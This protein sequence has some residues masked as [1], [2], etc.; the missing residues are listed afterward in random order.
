MEIS[1]K[2]VAERKVIKKVISSNQ[3]PPEIADNAPLNAAIAASLPANYNFE[4]H[5]IVWRLK[6]LNVRRVALQFP[7]GKSMAYTMTMSIVLNRQ[8]IT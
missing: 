8:K 5:K 3:V 2:P 1:A 6:Q 4:V 7:E